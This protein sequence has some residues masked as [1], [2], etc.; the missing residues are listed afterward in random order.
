[1]THIRTHRVRRSRGR[2]GVSLLEYALV[3]P[4]LVLVAFG[5]ADLSAAWRIKQVLAEAAREGARAAST[6]PNLQANDS[7]VLTVVSDIVETAGI[8]PGDYESSVSFPPGTPGALATSGVPVT[9]TVAHDGLPASGTSLSPLDPGFELVAN[10][11]M[12]YEMPIGSATPDEPPAL[13]PLPGP[14]V[15]PP[16][17]PPVPQGQGQ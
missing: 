11:T 12:R 2:R 1:M 10:S 4:I 5:I 6:M 9:V 8:S 14:P 3:L 7:R 16:G 17:G 15:L 13:P